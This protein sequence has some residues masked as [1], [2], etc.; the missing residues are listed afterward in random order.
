MTPLSR[1]SWLAGR[2]LSA[3][4]DVQR[5]IA[6]HL[7]AR[8]DELV[9]AGW[10]PVTAR[11]EAARVFGDVAA[12]S[13]ASRREALR[14]ER[15]QRW[16]EFAADVRRDIRVGIRGLVRH[17]GFSVIAVLTLALAIGANTTIY[18]LVHGVL[19][20]PLPYPQADRLVQVS[21]V[22]AKGRAMS[23]A[24]RNFL[25]WQDQIHP[26]TA[27]AVYNN[28]RFMS[29]TT[30]LGGDHP[31]RV[32]VMPVSREFFRV[33]AVRPEVG[34]VFTDEEFAGDGASV[35]VVSDRFWRA[36]L[37]AITALGA[38][39]LRLFGGDFTVVGVT[40]PGFDFPAGA[41]VWVPN[42]LAPA[43]IGARSS[44][45]YLA[46]GRLRDGM[47]IEQATRQL[48]ELM[49]RIRSTITDQ[50]EAANVA[51]SVRVVS[52]RDAMVGSTRQ[53]LLLL[54]AA[55]GLL[56][57]IA[58]TN[59]A[60]A[61]LARGTGRRL[62]IAVR[63]AIGAGRRRLVR[64]L[65]IESLIV[66]LLGGLIGVGLATES[67]HVVKLLGPSSLPR[68]DTVRLGWQA[69]FFTAVAIAF[70]AVLFGLLP[71]LRIVRA[72]IGAVLRTGGR[73]TTGGASERIWPILLTTQAMFA[74]A[75]LIGAGLLLRSFTAISRVDPGFRSTGVA[76]AALELTE[77]SYPDDIAT[78]R[79]FDQALAS[80]QAAPGVRAAGVTN[81][82]PLG[83]AGING[84]FEIEGR[85][86]ASGY[87]DYRVASGGYFRAMSIPLL[88]G[89]LFDD[90]DGP[91][92]GDVAVINQALA[93]RDWP[94]ASPVGHR[95]RRLANDRFVYGDRWLTI[96]GVVGNVRHGDLT[97][98][99]DPA[100]YV[101]YRQRP[102]RVRDAIIVVAGT[103]PDGRTAGLTATVRRELAG[104]D[105]DV[106]ITVST[107]DTFVASSLALRR[108]IMLVMTVFALAALIL[109]VVG[110]YGVVSYSVVR[111]TREIGIRMALGGRTAAVRWLMMRGA[112][113]AVVMGV[114]LGVAGALAATRAIG[115]LLYN[116]SPTDPGTFLGVVLLIVA[117]AWI[118]SLIPAWRSTKVDP[119]NVLRAE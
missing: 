22:D 35:A 40:P 96:V 27:F 17:S 97:R 26:F 47:T 9:T 71:A 54:L 48:G 115:T 30:V 31:V 113:S 114:V 81:H 73:G 100:I 63:S 98:V 85:T 52:L 55:G 36:N 65:F 105:P 87:A 4:E 79:Y 75:L 80:L 2:R 103:D 45:N 78:A 72:D 58:C 25:D 60:S 62:E 70:T 66:S 14:L 43:R 46:V 49:A 59:I 90:R 111:R 39:P 86:Q 91:E 18:T 32:Q 24:G 61:T 118:A 11:A 37:G 56:L 102:F 7:A 69:A 13:D 112:V 107:M 12:V 117:A 42:P 84:D 23:V 68:L 3:R 93:E 41:D 95:I 74:V 108:L 57:L 77:S 50:S 94:G 51:A 101:D 83:G 44:H 15:S 28:P 29:P 89:R 21:E 110:V 38:H 34:R 8:V 67:L 88:Q 92:T 20:Q 109:A 119:M 10:D 6:H 53:P 104:V 64:Q 19:L 5:E 33:F 82:L 106:P 1:N 76:T 99:P 116:V 16:R